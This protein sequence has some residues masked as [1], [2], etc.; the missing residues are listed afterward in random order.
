MT[1]LQCISLFG[2]LLFLLLLFYA[3]QKSYLREGYALL[4]LF[5]DIGMIVLSI[6][7]KS[8]DWIAGKLGIKMGP[9][10]LVLF[11]LGG[12]ILILFQQS[13][14]LSRHNEKIKRLAE[15]LSLLREEAAKKKHEE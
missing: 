8:M 11:M 13:V 7:P 10:V 2:S 14:A 9:F 1:L 6:V 4:W 3:L 5:I 12:M 15:E